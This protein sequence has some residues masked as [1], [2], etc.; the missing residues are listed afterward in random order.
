[1]GRRLRHV[2]CGGAGNVCGLSPKAN[3]IR[4]GPAYVLI[5]NSYGSTEED[6]EQT[7]EPELPATDEEQ[8]ASNLILPHLIKTASK[9]VDDLVQ[10]GRGG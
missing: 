4:S 9:T 3:W 10:V 5:L 7:Q 1:M 2:P 6:E 8:E